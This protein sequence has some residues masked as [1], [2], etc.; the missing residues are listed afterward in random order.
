MTISLGL[1]LRIGEEGEKR[2]I[3]DLEEVKPA[4][5]ISFRLA[6]LFLL[7]L[8]APR[9]HEEASPRELTREQRCHLVCESDADAHPPL[10]SVE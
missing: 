5:L 4:G 9:Q 7:L 8:L 1:V 3:Q 2:F 6:T 10:G